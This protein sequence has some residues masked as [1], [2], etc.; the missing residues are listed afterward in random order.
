[1]KKYDFIFGIGRDCACPL[2]LRKAGLQLMSLPW[3]TFP[4][5]PDSDGSDILPRLD[6]MGPGDSVAYPY[7][8]LH[9]TPLHAAGPDTKEKEKYD[10]RLGQFK[11]RMAGSNNCVLAVYMDTPRSAQTDI[12]VCKEAQRKLQ[13]FYPHVKVDFLLFSFA[14]D[15]PYS[16]RIVEDLGNGFT[17]VAFDFKDKTSDPKNFSVDLGQC[18]AVMRSLA[19]VRPYT[20]SAGNRRRTLGEKM[21]DVGAANVW[22]YFLYRR[23]RDFSRLRELLVPRL[24]LARLRRRKCDHVLSIGMNCEPAFR[25]SLSWGF[26]ES[27]PFSWASCTDPLRLAEVLREPGLIGDQGF[28][29]RDESLMWRCE[30]T[31]LSFHGKLAVDAAGATVSPEALA[32]DKDDLVRRLA[33][34]N[35]K[36]T[37][38]LSDDSS[39]AIIFRVDTAVALAE[40]ANAK[41]DAV[42]R[43]LEARGARNY[44]L[45]VI[46]EQTAHGRIA[47]A[48]NRVVRTVKAFNPRSAVA[49]SKMGDSIGW[50]AIYEEFAPKK[51]LSKKY[52]FK[53]EK[54]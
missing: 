14:P 45:V 11:K 5:N 49:N 21:R 31:G 40:D 18:A 53:F 22:Q 27:T 47:P 19:A 34:L 8:Y 2:A 24:L 41:I 26:V 1:M 48:P 54:T 37:R 33:Y 43:A 9:N 32:A 50:R 12:D 28:S 52:A 16:Q 35:E 51:I 20:T 29:F 23:R 13:A 38:I 4:M 10:R 42:Q 17:R 7:D 15:R 44:T 3:D 39:K 46:T 36:L 30:K 25:F 6:L